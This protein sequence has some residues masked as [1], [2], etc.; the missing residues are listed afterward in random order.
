MDQVPPKLAAEFERMLA[1]QMGNLVNKIVDL[2]RPD[3][4]GKVVE[5]AQFGK[6]GDSDVGY[7]TQE[8][9]GNTG[10][11]LVRETNVVWEDLKNIMR[12]TCAQLISP[13]GTRGPGPVSG[14]GLCAGM[15]VSTELREELIGVHTY[16]RI[17]AE[18][19][20]TT[21]SI[22]VI[23][24]IVDFPQYVLGAVHVGEVQRNAFALRGVGRIKPQQIIAE[25]VYHE[26]GILRCEV[27]NGVRNADGAVAR[28]THNAAIACTARN[29]SRRRDVSRKRIADVIHKAL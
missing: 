19:I 17:V 1:I 12:E 28:G 2:V 10:V 14:G 4:L 11:D 9:I 26:T 8:R 5:G 6:A 21:Y 23:D 7:A 27:G 15:N 3:N 16:D 24:M 13:A 20:R 18:E 29:R 25:R 22:P